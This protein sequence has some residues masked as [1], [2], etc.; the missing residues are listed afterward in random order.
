[1]SPSPTSTPQSTSATQT[2]SGPNY[3]DDDDGLYAEP[4]PEELASN[5]AKSQALVP[6]QKLETCPEL[7]I[8]SIYVE[9]NL[10]VVVCLSCEKAIHLDHVRSHLVTEHSLKGVPKQTELSTFLLDIGGLPTDQIIFPT[11]P[12]PPIVGLPTVDGFQCLEDDCDYI[13]T[14]ERSR[15]NHFQTEHPTQHANGDAIST[16]TLRVQVLYGFKRDRVILQ[17]LPDQPKPSTTDGYEKYMAQVALRPPVSPPTYQLPSDK[18]LQSHFL[19]FTNFGS[20]IE[21]KDIGIIRGLVESPVAQDR[22]YPIL[23]GCRSYFKHIASRLPQFGD[24]FLRWIM[25]LKS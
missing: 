5:Y 24:L 10:H 18:K 9:P 15:Y 12:V 25:T 23:A 16:S 14:S 11:L 19:T 17:V 2:I 4:T 3:N 22:Y 6:R 20:I 1:V 7:R 21:G 8:Y 13:S